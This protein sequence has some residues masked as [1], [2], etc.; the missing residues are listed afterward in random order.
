MAFLHLPN[1]IIT[2]VAKSLWYQ[3][4]LA[5]ASTCKRLHNLLTNTSF[6]TTQGNLYRQ[7]RLIT[8]GPVHHEAQL[9]EEAGERS[10]S[11]YEVYASALRDESLPYIEF[12]QFGI[13]LYRDE[14]DSL[15]PP[16]EPRYFAR[17]PL[18]NDLRARLEKLGIPISEI[19]H[20]QSK[21]GPR[22]EGFSSDAEGFFAALTPLCINLKRIEFAGVKTAQMPRRWPYIHAFFKYL[23]RMETQTH[24]TK[25]DTFIWSED[26]FVP[27]GELTA[28]M[29]LPSMRK[30]V[31]S[32]A[33]EGFHPRWNDRNNTGEF[34]WD[35]ELPRSRLEFLELPRNMVSKAGLER[36]MRC[37][38]GP[39][40]VHYTGRYFWELELRWTRLTATIPFAGAGGDEWAFTHTSERDSS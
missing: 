20:R 32:Q 8:L 26:N 22:D 30:M 29:A 7:Y 25:L 37:I 18:W 12:L 23:S 3:D 5:L 6:M 14:G 33:V 28:V 31:L 10:A 21:F 39:C 24:L 9:E 4:L 11:I 17:E 27:M 2:H 35:E 16:L 34:K 36:I 13:E 15:F 40:I 38:V 19:F 1:E